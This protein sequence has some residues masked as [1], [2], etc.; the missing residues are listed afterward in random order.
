MKFHNVFLFFALLV[1]LNKPALASPEAVTG[2]FNGDGR[3]DVAFGIV[4]DTVD[5]VERAGTVTIRYGSETGILNGR[6]QVLSQNTPGMPGVAEVGDAFGTALAVG[7]FNMDGTD[8]LAI[9]VGGEDLEG[10]VAI[11]D[12][13]AVHVVYGSSIGLAPA[14]SHVTQLITSQ[15]PFIS[16]NARNSDRFGLALTVG[17]FNGRG[18]DDL[19]IGLRGD[20]ALIIINGTED[21]LLMNLNRRIENSD[22]RVGGDAAQDGESFTNQ[23]VAADF[24]GDGIDDLAASAPFH[25]PQ[26]RNGRRQEAGGLVYVL[27]GSSAGLAAPFGPATTTWS[28]AD[29]SDGPENFSLAG[30]G[31]ALA[32]ADFNGDRNDDIAIGAPGVTRV[33]V[34]QP[35]PRP[36][37]G[38]VVALYGSDSGI[39]AADATVIPKRNPVSTSN[40]FGQTL[41]VRRINGDGFADLIIAANEAPNLGHASATIAVGSRRGLQPLEYFPLEA[42]LRLFPSSNAPPLIDPGLPIET[43]QENPNQPHCGVVVP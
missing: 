3:E 1:F 7:D 21:G 12:A 16:Q 22:P 37:P 11:Q 2:D 15:T 40:R 35:D 33:Q 26:N 32:A 43:C 5:G 13:G 39:S 28:I 20:D 42:Y 36:A 23:M 41:S 4:N 10:Q 34:G 17:N 27:Y 30:F 24:N 29:V 6:K 38:F 14:G 25:N 9:G 8:D 19:A 31:F 18:G